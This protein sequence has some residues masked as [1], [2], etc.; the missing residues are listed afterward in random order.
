MIFKTRARKIA[1]V[2]VSV[3]L[4]KPIGTDKAKAM[5]QI[6]SS[7]NNLSFFTRMAL[8]NCA[9]RSQQTT[10]H[11]STLCAAKQNMDTAYATNLTAIKG[12]YSVQ[13]VSFRACSCNKCFVECPA[14][15]SAGKN[16]S[17][18]A[19]FRRKRCAKVCIVL[20]E[21]MVRTIKRLPRKATES[22][23]NSTAVKIGCSVSCRERSEMTSLEG[24]SGAG[25]PR[26]EK[27]PGRAEQFGFVPEPLFIFS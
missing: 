21:K 24:I 12:L 22:A 11:R 10:Y 5:I 23:P 26:Q 8:E 20:F 7:D 1:K 27:F 14:I 3:I 2:L 18:I 25:G 15:F 19:T 9:F 17:A 13:N 4:H 6:N 16:K